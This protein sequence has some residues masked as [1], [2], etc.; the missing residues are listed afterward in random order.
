MLHKWLEEWNDTLLYLILLIGMTVFFSCYWKENFQIRYA[1]AMVQQFLE[2]TVAKGKITLTEYEAL[3]KKVT[4][5]HSEF[6]VELSGIRY[7]LQP[8]YAML[9]REQLTAYYTKRNIKK[10][11]KKPEKKVSVVEEQADKLQM[12]QENNASVMAAERQEYLPLPDESTGIKISAVRPLQ[13]VYEGEALITLCCVRD[14]SGYYYMEAEPVYAVSSGKVSLSL[15]LGEAVY[16]IPV[17]VW[18]YPRKMQCSQGHE[19]VNSKKILEEYKKSGVVLCP[20]CASIPQQIKCNEPVLY[21]KT[22]TELQGHSWITV[23]YLDGHTEVITPESEEWTDSYDKNFCGIQQVTI[24]YRGVEKQITVV[25]ENETCKQ[26]GAACNERCR[27]DYIKF[28]YCIRCMTEVPLF[29][30]KVYEEEQKISTK[31]LWTKLD[32]CGEYPMEKGSFLCVRLSRGKYVSYMQ[33]KVL[34]TGK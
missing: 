12:Q 29:T 32:E 16:Q 10:E 27:E 20:Y 22:G 5:L 23:T 7:E 13:E 6:E 19:V 2:E 33:R 17:E 34:R 24:I 3:V 21:L 14:M 30:G 15:T 26:C 8:V 9:P 31:K 11:W 28:P 18:C 1:E 25:T 4:E